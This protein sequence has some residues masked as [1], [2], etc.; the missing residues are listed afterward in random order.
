ML[1]PNLKEANNQASILI[2]L[3]TKISKTHFMSLCSQARLRLNNETRIMNQEHTIT[4]TLPYQPL[5][6]KLSF[7][8]DIVEISL[9]VHIL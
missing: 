2:Q 9:S 3:S 6:L 4:Y 7:K 5:L 8:G 1:N